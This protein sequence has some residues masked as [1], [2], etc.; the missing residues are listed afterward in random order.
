MAKPPDGSVPL[1]LPIFKAAVKL[2]LHHFIHSFLRSLNITP[3][4]FNPMDCKALLGHYVLWKTSGIQSDFSLMNSRGYIKPKRWPEGLVGILLLAGLLLIP[5]SPLNS[6]V[7]LRVG[8]ILS[9][10]LLEIGALMNLIMMIM[11]PFSFYF[12]VIY[13]RL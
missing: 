4:Q 12:Q 11:L 7:R 6:L 13:L 2:P 10:L 1:Y 3:T 5:L 9:F 8:K